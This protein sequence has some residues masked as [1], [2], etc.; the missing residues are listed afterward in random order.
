MSRS[1][2]LCCV[3]KAQ[4]HFPSFAT[5]MYQWNNLVL[6]FMWH[7]C[8]WINA[9][10][11]WGQGR[12]MKRK[13]KQSGFRSD[14]TRPEAL[15]SVPHASVSLHNTPH[16]LDLYLIKSLCSVRHPTICSSSSIKKYIFI[17]TPRINRLIPFEMNYSYLFRKDFV[18]A[19]DSTK[20]K[21]N[22][23]MACIHSGDHKH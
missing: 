15:H 17:D 12:E 10:K 22:R 8:Y 5:R 18:T 20:R 13:V 19:S 7:D 11:V 6:L 4:M 21:S 14:E 16:L 3:V 1:P 2:S 23:F 9:I